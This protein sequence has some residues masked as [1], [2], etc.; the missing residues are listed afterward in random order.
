[1]LY[2]VERRPVT[3]MNV[4]RLERDLERVIDSKWLE[5][6]ARETGALMRSRK[7][8]VAAFVSTLVLGFAGA[9]TRTLAALR[10]AYVAA[11]GTE[12]EPSSFY[13][14]FNDGMVRL[15]RAC[16]ARA[17]DS[18]AEPT[19]ALAGLLRSFKDL[20]VTDSTVVRLR[21]LLAS[22]YAACRT[23]HTLAAA[24]LHV[25]MSVLGCGPRTVKVT[26][27]RVHDNVMLRIGRW[28]QGRLLLFDL[29]YY[30]FQAFDCISRNG[31][32]YIS[33][34]K[35]NANP[36]IVACN[37]AW[38]GR[39]VPVVGERLQDVLPLL[40]RSVLDAMIQV[41][42]R[43]RVYGGKRSWATRTVRLVAVY[44]E[45]AKRYHLY[46]TNVGPERLPAEDVARTYATRWEIELLFK[47]MKSYYALDEIPSSKQQVVECLLLATVLTAIVARTL[48]TAVRRELTTAGRRV[49]AGRFAAVFTTLAATLLHAIISTG[50]NSRR[51]WQQIERLLK[52][53]VIDPNVS[54][55]L[56]IE[57]VCLST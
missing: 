29:G 46:V 20:V 39:A 13:D 50:R 48:L 54:R 49:P 8:D 44:N 22:S 36:L 47:E 38:R 45:E 41:R 32:F 2:Y 3:P 37:L 17:M 21:D 10:R 16:L 1:M 55:V 33:R 15:L 31:G 11:T 30:D 57:P 40:K 19:Q 5:K 12:I 14:R 24:K 43:R 56:N 42:F 35:I 4:T 53:E 52:A 18:A 7:I 23:N 34:L 26:A 27:E 28:V 25:V 51:C 6:T 9:R